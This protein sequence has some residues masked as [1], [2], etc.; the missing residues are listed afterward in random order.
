MKKMLLIALALGIGFS[1]FAQDQKK[2]LTAHRNVPVGI[3]QKVVADA[4]TVT[5]TNHASATVKNAIHHAMNTGNKLTGLG[6]GP[7]V[8]GVEFATSG[9]MLTVQ[10]PNYRT[11]SSN[12]G[13]NLVA[14]THRGGG[15]YGSTTNNINVTYTSD[16]GATFDS[17]YFNMNLATTIGNRYP[18]GVIVNPTGNTTPNQAYIGYLGPYW[19][20]SLASATWLGN[21]LGSARLDGNSADMHT[22]YP[23]WDTAGP[24]EMTAVNLASCTDLTVHGAHPYYMTV[25]ADGSYITNLL[26]TEDYNGKL[27]TGASGDSIVWDTV[28][29]NAN[30]MTVPNDAPG[31]YL[32]NYG[33]AWNEDGSIGYIYYFGVDSVDHPDHYSVVPIVYKSVDKGLT[34]TK[35]PVFDFSTIS[36]IEDSIMPVDNNPSLKIPMIPGGNSEGDE[37]GG[38]VDNNGNL[39]IVTEVYGQ[40]S[41]DPDSAAYTYTGDKQR[42]YDLYMK[43]GG[44]WDAKYITTIQS[45][46]VLYTDP[47]ALPDGTSQAM[48]WNHRLGVTRTAD[49]KKM[50]ATWTDVSDSTTPE[51]TLPQIFGYGWDNVTGCHT[52]VKDFT[53]NT[54]VDGSCLFKYAADRVLTS[55]TTGLVNYTIPCTATLPNSDGSAARSLY[56]LFN[57][58]NLF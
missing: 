47:A 36:T 54:A 33:T 34:W 15:D 5:S 7:T 29:F 14:F 40:T 22:Y 9:N 21:Y 55:G 37:E 27:V 11:L 51:I 25:T 3:T 44:G 32:F 43:T 45:A 18:S 12:P 30:F 10:F 1:S 19:T 49:G 39:H 41:S 24:L 8:G 52:Q 56:S 2:A 35:Q 50:F 46:I 42:L 6:A 28:H 16:N 38:S 57:I 48:G 23:T 20:G 17:V 26:Y 13:L 53:V 58:G 4:N 31:I